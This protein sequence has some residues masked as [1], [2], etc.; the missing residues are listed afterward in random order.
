MDDLGERLVQ[1]NSAE[2]YEG[3]A[4]YWLFLTESGIFPFV[5]WEEQ[6]AKINDYCCYLLSCLEAKVKEFAP[7]DISKDDWDAPATWE[8]H[9][10]LTWE[11]LYRDINKCTL[12]SLLLVF[13]E[14]SLSEIANWF[15]DKAGLTS[16]WKKVRNPKVSD[17]L[18]QIGTCCKADLLQDLAEELSYYDT[19]RKIRN[20]FVHNEWEQCTDR[21]KKFVL[22]E[23]I[24]M[25]SHV[26]AK[27]ENVAMASG[28]IG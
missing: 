27:V 13:L 5:K 8:Y 11:F 12:L 6:L 19:V 17:Y 21:Y 14:S 23:V 20:Q 15:S 28:L 10:L 26:L 16:A 9:Q 7:F 2:H 4:G 18:L 25:I 3:T 24:D 22:A 1:S